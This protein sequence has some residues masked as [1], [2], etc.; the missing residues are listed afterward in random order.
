MDPRRVEQGNETPAPRPRP[1][2]Q[3]GASAHGDGG[4]PGQG[5]L[6]PR[7]PWQLIPLVIG[8]CVRCEAGWG[9]PGQSQTRNMAGG[10][11][12]SRAGQGPARVVEISTLGKRPSDA[13]RPPYCTGRQI[14]P[15]PSAP[16]P[17]HPDLSVP[18]LRSCD[19]QFTPVPLS[20]QAV[21]CRPVPCCTNEPSARTAKHLLPLSKGCAVRMIRSPPLRPNAPSSTPV[22]E[23][24]TCAN[25]PSL[26]EA[27]QGQLVLRPKYQHIW[28]LLLKTLN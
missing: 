1:R 8:R 18:P 12:Q 4:R 14:Q 11:Q 26:A 10:A 24:T 13:M 5:Q 2:G 23:Y 3:G 7:Q 20:Q 19:S 15:P 27:A 25:R 6:Q 9:H 21:S 22:H 16:P 28:R 17:D